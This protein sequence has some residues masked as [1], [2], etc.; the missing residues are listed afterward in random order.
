MR[1]D[2]LMIR[3]TT[4]T[5]TVSHDALERHIGVAAAYADLISMGRPATTRLTRSQTAATR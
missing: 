2:T 1:G 5:S 3:G 4:P